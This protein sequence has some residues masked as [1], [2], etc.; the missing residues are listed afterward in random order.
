MTEWNN[1]FIPKM[2]L[3]ANFNLNFIIKSSFNKITQCELN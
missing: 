1:I 2:L 3:R